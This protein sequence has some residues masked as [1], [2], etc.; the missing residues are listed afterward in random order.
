MYVLV[1]MNLCS[2][3]ELQKL[4]SNVIVE[5]IYNPNYKQFYDNL[6]NLNLPYTVNNL[7]IDRYH[8][9]NHIIKHEK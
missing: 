1:D 4:C 5:Y 9:I 3:L 2:P 8:L 7:I 6:I